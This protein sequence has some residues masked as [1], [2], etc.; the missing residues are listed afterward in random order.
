MHSEIFPPDSLVQP[1]EL[2]PEVAPLDVEVQHPGVV[3][4]HAEGPVR[5]V[6]GGLPQDLVQ[7]GPVG[8]RELQELLGVRRQ[9]DLLGILRLGLSLCFL[10]LELSLLLL[11]V[12]QL[13]F[14]RLLLVGLLLL[15]AARDGGVHEEERLD[16]RLQHQHGVVVGRLGQFLQAGGQGVP[17]R[18]QGQL[19]R[20]GLEG[21]SH[22][23]Q[24]FSPHFHLHR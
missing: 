24:S 12:G 2:G 10:G 15:L 14:P 20:Q 16:G 6:R 21:I 22:R 19:V 18:G 8:L 1:L 23:L 13:L 17:Q 11:D 4:Q 7:D 5:Q 9:K 3:H